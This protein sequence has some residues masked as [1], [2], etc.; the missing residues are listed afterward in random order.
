MD[1]NRST[2]SCEAQP[3]KGD[4]HERKCGATGTFRLS[5][6][7]LTAALVALLMASGYGLAQSNSATQLAELM[8]LQ[9]KVRDADTRT[10][11]DAFHRVWSIALASDSS[12]VKSSALTL[13]AE[14]AGSSSDH[15]R[16]PAIYA[17]ADIANST[18]DVPLK[19][20]ALD[21]LH[22]PLQAGQ[23]PVRD[24]AIDAVNIIVA[25]GKS[26]D[27]VMAALK[28]LS[29]P[30][31]SG[32]NGVRIPAINA[33]VKAAARSNSDA[34]RNAALDLLVDPLDSQAIIGGMEVRMLSVVAVEKI[35]TDASES[36]TKGKAMGLMLSYAGKD[37][38]EPEARKRAAE[39]AAQIKASMHEGSRPPSPAQQKT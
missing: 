11:V 36:A 24:V 9:D 4:S 17:I 21:T 13:M 7:R 34:A 6:L 29:E 10:R 37:S 23:V 28:A 5:I 25:S 1:T 3:N 16:M 27:L 12:E 14:P 30:V 32:N 2:L 31:K 8:S 18:S 22:D 33:I 26:D 15:I 35:G 39:A 38:W 19:I 20:K